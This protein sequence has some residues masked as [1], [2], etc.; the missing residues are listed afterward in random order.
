MDK[1]KLD[2]HAPY[3]NYSTKR[4]LKDGKIS[5][6]TVLT[7]AIE[8]CKLISNIL[9]IHKKLPYNRKMICIKLIQ[10][11]FY[12]HHIIFNLSLISL[13]P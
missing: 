8:L 10:I 5:N 11:I 3:W 12:Y 4:L 6:G 13:K 9:P 7:K 1:E 2:I